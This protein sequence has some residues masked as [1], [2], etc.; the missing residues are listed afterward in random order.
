MNSRRR[1]YENIAAL[2]TVQLLSYAAPLV[3]VPYLVRVLDPAQFGLVSFAQGLVLYFSVITDF[4]FDFSATRAIAARR[5]EPGI[6]S[7][8]FWSTLCAKA[9]L[10][11]GSA[12]A[13][14]LLIV[15]T[16]KLRE[17]P[18]LFAVT[19]LYVIGTALFPVWL[20]QGLEQM[21]LAALVFG[22]A[23]LLTVPALFL[24]VRHPQDYVKA[25]AIQSS[26]EVTASLL[27]APIVWRHI[28][29]RW[30]RPS[31][32]DIADAFRQGWPLFLSGSALYLCTS[33]TPVTLGFVSD[34][35]QVGY[36]SAAD[37]LI[38]AATSLLS[39]A[40]QALYPHITAM[41]VESTFSALQFIRK[42]LISI[43]LLSLGASLLIFLLAKPLSRFVL[44]I[45][46]VESAQVL[47]W[48]SPL[49]LLSGLMSVFGTQTM[50]VF[51]MD[52]T[53]SR[54]MSTSAVAGIPLTLALSYVFGAQGAAAGSAALAAVMVAA[55]MTTLRVRGL[56]IWRRSGQ[57]S[58][59]MLA[60]AAPKNTEF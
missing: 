50:L 1:L 47:R 29:V 31:R 24:L 5:H 48:L 34:R 55:M 6:V 57:R 46:F 35:I 26:V 59:V 60:A 53:M 56:S 25:A 51:E 18:R 22:T 9:I 4:G 40:S 2:A 58:S 12:V 33:S 10:L 28:R 37:K 30:Y 15:V 41:K 3:T 54:I 39:P 44:G 52:S 42:S 23:R 7:Q 20:F 27:A 36:F 16:P 11:L 32:F 38:K 13:L 43:G 49:P 45:E 17:T 14:T 19:F 21:K 8:V